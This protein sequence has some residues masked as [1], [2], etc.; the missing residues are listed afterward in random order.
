MENKGDYSGDYYLAHPTDSRKEVREW[1][2]NFEKKTGIILINPFYDVPRDDIKL[3]DAGVCHKYDC[4]PKI[5]I[6][7]DVKNIKNAKKGLIAIIN[8]H[9]SY[10]TIQEIIY[11]KTLFNKEVYSI[12]T[13]GQENHPW[14]RY[15]SDRVFT[16]F[17]DFEDYFLNKKN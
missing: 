4:D 2:L 6:E 10:G 16:T 8:E 14:L 11:A 7:R 3:M 13:N 15:H 17:R 12:I 5:T 1:E 9:I